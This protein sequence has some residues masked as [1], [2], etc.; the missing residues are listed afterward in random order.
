MSLSVRGETMLEGVPG[1]DLEPEECYWELAQD[2]SGKSVLIH[3]QKTLGKKSSDAKVHTHLFPTSHGERL[4][5]YGI[6]AML[7]YHYLVSEYLASSCEAPEEFYALSISEQADRVWQGLFVNSTPMS[8]PCRGVLTTQAAQVEVAERDLPAIRR[9]YAG[10]DAVMFNEKMMRLAR[11]RYIITSHDPFDP[12]QLHLCLEPPYEMPRYKSALA[13][14][15]LLEGRWDE[16]TKSLEQSGKP[17]PKRL[18]FSGP[19]TLRQMLSIDGRAPDPTTATSIGK[20]KWVFITCG[21]SESFSYCRGVVR[22][23]SADILDADLSESV[24]VP[25][26]QQVLDALLLPLCRDFSLALSLR[27]GTRR[28]VNPSLQLAGD[29]VGAAELRS[30]GHLCE[31]NPS[32]KFLFTVLSR[33]DQHE[34]A[35]LSSKFR[36]LHLWGCWWY[37][38]KPSVVTEVTSLRLEMLGM[39]FTYQASSARVHDQLIYKWIHSRSLLSKLLVGKYSDLMATGWKV[40]RGDIRRDVYRLLG[41]A[42]EDFL[43]KPL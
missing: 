43:Q 23:P 38:N 33:N 3:L 31:A 11:L 22:P 30:L 28:A 42:F 13:L 39:N 9:W 2:A 37:C 15:A 20:C 5:Q 17:G 8:E 29:A 40:S 12:D 10:Q 6:D 14:D 24:F 32:V 16:V 7:T 21:T 27:M 4:M 18:M 26:P 25:S 41:G 1:C 19:K 36:N 35:V 34:A